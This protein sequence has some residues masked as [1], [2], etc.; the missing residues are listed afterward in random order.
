MIL[1]NICPS[2][3]FSLIEASTI[4]RFEIAESLTSR[5]STCCCSAAPSSRVP[6]RGVSSLFHRFVA[7]SPWVRSFW[8][9]GPSGGPSDWKSAAC[10]EGSSSRNVSTTC[11]LKKSNGG[12]DRSI[13]WLKIWI[14]KNEHKSVQ[15]TR[16]RNMQYLLYLKKNK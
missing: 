16:K 12:I 10:R 3:Q 11:T 5:S 13:D 9:S 14:E 7:E 2:D 4:T 15:E 8:R 1:S 6:F